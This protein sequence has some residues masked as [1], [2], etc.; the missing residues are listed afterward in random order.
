M[1]TLPTVQRHRERVAMMAGW[2]DPKDFLSDKELFSDTR[3]FGYFDNVLQR[4]FDRIFFD[5]Y[6]QGSKYVSWTVLKR[7]HEHDHD[8]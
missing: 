4:Q 1:A 3:F 8:H 7:F 6:N 2:L 5:G